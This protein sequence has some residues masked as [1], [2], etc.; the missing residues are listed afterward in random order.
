M[1]VK[2]YCLEFTA[3]TSHREVQHGGVSRY[4]YV[5]PSIDGVWDA[6]SQTHFD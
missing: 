2:W 5:Y 4:N 6:M 1:F 3:A